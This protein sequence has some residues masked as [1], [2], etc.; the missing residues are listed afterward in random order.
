MIENG[1][2]IEHFDDWVG[3]RPSDNTSKQAAGEA[4]AWAIRDHLGG[5]VELT[6]SQQRCEQMMATN[7]GGRPT[8]TAEPLY[9]TP[10]TQQEAQP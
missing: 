4:V 3:F 1:T 5:L 7:G 9:T 10:P 6:A 8:W 2:L